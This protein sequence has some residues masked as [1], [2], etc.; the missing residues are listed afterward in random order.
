MASG[1][2][3]LA[4]PWGRRDSDFNHGAK[5]QQI[6][7]SRKLRMTTEYEQAVTSLR[8]LDWCGGCLHDQTQYKTDAGLVT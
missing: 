4:T 1:H 5:F 8:S 6:Y 2:Q 7:L 3:V